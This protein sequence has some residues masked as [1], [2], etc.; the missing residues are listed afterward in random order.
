M[1]VTSIVKL[2]TEFKLILVVFLLSLLTVQVLDIFYP[3]EVTVN[4]RECDGSII[5]K[6]TGGRDE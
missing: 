6:E 5:Q 2:E 1:K 3:K 4:Y